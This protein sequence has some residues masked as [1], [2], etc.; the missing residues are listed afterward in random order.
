MPK[1]YTNDPFPVRLVFDDAAT[2]RYGGNKMYHIVADKTF[3]LSIHTSP[4]GNDIW[5]TSIP[6][7]TIGGCVSSYKNLGN[8]A[9]IEE[10]AF[11]IEDAV[12]NNG[13]IRKGAYIR[14]NAIVDCNKFYMGGSY[15]IT[16][17]DGIHLDLKTNIDS[18]P[19]KL[20]NPLSNKGYVTLTGLRDILYICGIS[21]VEYGNG[22]TIFDPGDVPTKY[23]DIKQCVIRYINDEVANRHF[24]YDNEIKK[25]DIIDPYEYTPEEIDIIAGNIAKLAESY[26]MK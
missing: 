23:Y 12:V 1:V 10:G 6:R 24:R 22:F 14:G 5:T 8:C 7:G 13:L 16:V 26:F 17:G 4:K 9:W 3:T 11:V 25:N 18:C 20:W 21:G 2:A 15:E 19:Y